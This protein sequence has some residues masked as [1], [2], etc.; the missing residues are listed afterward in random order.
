MN[1]KEEVLLFNSASDLRIFG[2]KYLYVTKDQI[3]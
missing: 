3:N 2:E 1:D